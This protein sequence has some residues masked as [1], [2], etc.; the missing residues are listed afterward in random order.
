MKARIPF[1]IVHGA[2]GVLAL[3]VI[4]G[5]WSSTVLAELFGDAA[6][7]ATV[8]SAI[9]WCL[10]VFV[11]LL[12]VTGATGFA[13]AGPNPKGALAT[14]LRRMR[15]IAANG[16]LVLAPSALFLAWRAN[17]GQFDTAFMV[18][19]AAEL[20]AGAINATLIALNIRDGFRLAGRF[21]AMATQTRSFIG[22]VSAGPRST[23]ASTSV[24][25]SHD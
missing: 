23:S 18:V 16:L 11:P 9:A 6:V 3:L 8:K 2:A 17:A 4:L 10:L 12:A 5:F 1:H 13:M 21:R 14:K 15:I 20:A 24:R 7:V 25:D 22:G 19:Q